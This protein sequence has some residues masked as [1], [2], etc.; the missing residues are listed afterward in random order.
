VDDLRGLRGRFGGMWVPENS[1]EVDR[2][3]LFSISPALVFLT[4]PALPKG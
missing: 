1:E 2:T 4:V 3:P